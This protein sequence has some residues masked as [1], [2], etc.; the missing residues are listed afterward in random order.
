MSMLKST[1]KAA[2]LA[3]AVGV[4]CVAHAERT[5]CV[6]EQTDNAVTLA[7]GGVDELDYEL[8]LAHGATDGGE[9]KTAWDS[10]EKVADVAY[11]QTTLTYEVPAA[12]RDGRPMRFFLMQT[13]GIQMAKEYTSIRST[14]QQWINTGVHP[15]TNNWVTDFR[16]KTGATL[17]NDTTF[18]GQKWGGNNYLF[19]LQNDGGT[20]F[21]FYGSS[22][23]TVSGITPVANTDYRLVIDAS[24]YLTLAGGGVEARKGINRMPSTSDFA[25]FSDYAGG[26]KGTFT[27]YRMKIAASTTPVFDFV[28][29]ANAAGD[30]GLYDQLNDVFYPNQTATPFVAGD[31]LPPGRAGRVADETPTFRFRP[32]V[33]V[34]SATADAV[35]LAFAN[36]GSEPHT[37]YVAYGATDCEDQKNAWDN[38][39]EVATIPADAATYVYTLPAALKADGV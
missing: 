26:H 7:F 15:A 35:T 9:D 2:A 13:F 39:A 27:F 14:G 1:V 18:F 8:F 24:S 32:T 21:R 34:A 36:L 37:L 4:S 12:L 31:E 11:D 10:F 5:V 22:S 16:F 6:S 28:P 19:I 38:F 30:I 33:S 20:K 25:I 3:F 29:A 17:P 23:Q